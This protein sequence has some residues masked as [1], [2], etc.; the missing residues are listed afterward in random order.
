MT[1]SQINLS[2]C[3]SCIYICDLYRNY[4]YM[5]AIKC[6]YEHDGIKTINANNIF[7]LSMKIEISKY[8]NKIKQTLHCKHFMHTS[9]ICLGASVNQF[10]VNKLLVLTDLVQTGL[11]QTKKKWKLINVILR[12]YSKFFFILWHSWSSCP[13]EVQN[14]ILYRAYFIPLIIR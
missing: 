7:R 6:Q 13:Y 8:G 10:L 9:K 14:R 5:Y 3:T 11:I 1:A 2:S 4:M 12:V